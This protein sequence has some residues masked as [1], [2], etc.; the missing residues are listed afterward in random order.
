MGGNYARICD[1]SGAGKTETVDFYVV[2]G[3]GNN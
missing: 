1:G 3:D 2:D